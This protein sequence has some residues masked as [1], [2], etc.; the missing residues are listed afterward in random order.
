MGGP[1]TRPLDRHRQRRSPRAARSR[2]PRR[3]LQLPLAH[4]RQTIQR[5]ALPPGL[6]VYHQRIHGLRSAPRILDPVRRQQRRLHSGVSIRDRSRAHNAIG[7]ADS[8]RPDLAAFPK[9][10]PAHIGYEIQIIDD[11]REKFQSGSVYTFVPSR[12]G[13]QRPL[14]WNSMDIESRDGAI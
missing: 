12:T 5:L 1:R 14:S 11:V 7:E 3:A 8:E 13:A 4:R 2:Q 9:T 6:A 10:T